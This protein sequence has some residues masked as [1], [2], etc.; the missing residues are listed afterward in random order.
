MKNVFHSLRILDFGIQIKE[1]QK[2][3]DY[4]TMNDI[5]NKIENDENFNPFNYYKEFME[6]SE[7][8]KN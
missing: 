7:K 2:I 1:H 6:L 8:I 5:K 3:V 4:S